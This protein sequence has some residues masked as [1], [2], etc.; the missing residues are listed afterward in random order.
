MQLGN[1]AAEAAKQESAMQSMTEELVALRCK[2][3]EDAEFR[4]RSLRIVTRDPSDTNGSGSLQ[5]GYWRENRLS[6]GSFVSQ[7][8]SSD[9]VFSQTP[10]GTCTPISAADTSPEL[11]QAP[12][13]HS[14]EDDHTKE[15]Q[16]CHGVQPSEAWDVVHLLKEESRALKARIARY[17]SANEDALSLLDILSTVR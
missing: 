12:Q 17:E 8:S 2:L 16:N 10:L 4:S 9:S 6:G 11:Y 5:D 3:R 1:M 13:S 7:K 15:C 14:L